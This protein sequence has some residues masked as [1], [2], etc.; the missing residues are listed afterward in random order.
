MVGCAK[1]IL[2]ARPSDDRAT[3]AALRLIAT[4]DERDTATALAF[5]DGLEDQALETVTAG[6]DQIKV[7]KN[8][9][10]TTLELID[11][12]V[13]IN[14]VA[15]AIDKSFVKIRDAYL[16]LLDDKADDVA[17]RIAEFRTDVPSPRG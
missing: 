9:A 15:E 11:D 13:R 14:R 7:A 8:G 2:E 10:V 6:L 4:L 17:P 16:L 1:A 12:G 5:A 3:W